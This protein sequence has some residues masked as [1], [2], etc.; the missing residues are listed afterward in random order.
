[1]AD[2]TS[3][4]RWAST[5]TAEEQHFAE[6]RRQARQLGLPLEEFLAAEKDHSSK[7]YKIDQ[8]VH[9]SDSLMA[10]I[11]AALRDRDTVTEV[12]T[13][14]EYIVARTFLRD[15]NKNRRNFMEQRAMCRSYVWG[16]DNRGHLRNPGNTQAMHSTRSNLFMEPY[17]RALAE[18]RGE[19]YTPDPYMHVYLNKATQ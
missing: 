19:I 18:R 16:P 13:Q 17:A 8:E 4:T 12:R 5:Q 11:S 14:D 3:S 7:L 9:Q 6:R 1:M 15:E 10:R 2:S